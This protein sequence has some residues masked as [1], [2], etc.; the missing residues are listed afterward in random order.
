MDHWRS[1]LPATIHDVDYEETVADLEGVARRLLSACGLDWH[2]ACLEFHRTRR[3][4][5]TASMTQ[6]RQ[7]I[8]RRSV[9][10]WKSYERE[11]AGLFDRVVSGGDPQ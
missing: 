11:L 3:P 4:V 10:R 6:V 2:P 5:R 1:V 9:G 7:P 8:Y